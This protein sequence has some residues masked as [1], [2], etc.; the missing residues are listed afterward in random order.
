[1]PAPFDGYP[2]KYLRLRANF[3]DQVECKKSLSDVE[4]IS[5]LMSYTTSI[6]KEVIENYSGLSNGCQLALKVLE[7][8]FGQSAMM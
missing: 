2:A 3:R 6:A 1:M 5:Y 7:H 4:K 8:R